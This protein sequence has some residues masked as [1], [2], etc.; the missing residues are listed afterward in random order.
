LDL[1]V[2]EALRHGPAPAG[3]TAAAQPTLKA[4]ANEPA[5]ALRIDKTT[6]AF[7]IYPRFSELVQNDSNKPFDTPLLFDQAKKLLNEQLIPADDT[8]FSVEHARVLNHLR[9]QRGVN[10]QADQAGQPQAKM[11]YLSARRTVQGFAIDGPGSRVMLA[12]D[13]NSDLKAS[14]REWKKASL[15]GEVNAGPD[16]AQV[17]VEIERQILATQPRS[18][19][20]VRQIALAYYDGNKELLQPV[21]RFVAE[22][23][24]Q[25]ASIGSTE[26]VVGYVAYASTSEAVPALGGDA[27]LA[28]P[29]ESPPRE[30]A[31]SA[32]SNGGQTALSLGRYVVRDDHAGW[33]T[34]AAAFGA[35]IMSPTNSIVVAD[36][37][38]YAATP[39]LFTRDKDDFVN[40]V[41]LALVEAH[42]FPWGFTTFRDWGDP[43]RFGLDIPTT[44]YGARGGG[45]LKHSILHSCNAVP[46]PDDTQY[47]AQ[48]W[49]GVFNGLYSVV[50]YRTSMFID[51]GAGAAFGRSLRE[52]VAV[53]PAWFN[54]VL[55]LNL[56]NID[57]YTTAQCE[58]S[59]PMGRPSAVTACDASEV[60][61]AGA[62]PTAPD[63][64]EAW[65]V[66]DALISP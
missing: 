47:W 4:D 63:C 21:Y 53:V 45:K 46:A 43:V 54:T 5:P 35:S 66:G 12:Y 58:G 51:D 7:E 20:H 32:A 30:A 22:V 52:G 13:A 41:D 49:W 40:S 55:S 42:G 62:G 61:I 56:Y 16:R 34:D 29:P 24:K 25:R 10:G 33:N 27:A 36:A 28:A 1:Q 57:P 31:R 44:G 65:W 8:R 3:K 37:Q 14:L 18:T 60:S 17:R 59:E 23:D 15:S 64:L 26:H 39:R 38:Y 6:G 11:L 50:G 48:G 19:V 9:I 2:I